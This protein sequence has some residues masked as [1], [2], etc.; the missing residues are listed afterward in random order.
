M[1]MN[2]FKAAFKGTKKRTSQ[3]SSRRRVAKINKLSFQHLEA[4]NL[5]AGIYFSSGEVTIAGDASSN[6]GSFIEVDSETYRARLDGFP[7]QS[8]SKTSVSKVIFIGFEGDDEFTNDTPVESLILGN[9]GNDTLIGGI[10]I[11]VVNGGDGDD[12]IQGFGG[13]DR[14]LGGLG[15]DV[16][17]GG[18]GN[19][20]VFGG[21]GLNRLFGNEDADLI[22]GGSDVDTISGGDG[23]DQIFPLGGDDIVN[24]GDGGLPGATNPADA[25]LVLGGSGNDVLSGGLGLNI[26]Y[27]GDGDDQVTGGDGENRMHGQNGSDSLISGAGNDY[28]AGQ[29]GDDTISGG[30]GND[31]IIPGFGDDVVDAGDGNDFV[32]FSF[33]FNRFNITISGDELVVD[34]TVD[35]EGTDLANNTEN[36]RFSDGDRVA[37][38]DVI[39]RVTINP[40][41]VSN[42]NGSNTAEFLGTAVE[43]AEIKRLIDEIYLQAQVDVE[44][45][46][47]QTYDN[48]FANIGNGGTRPNSD[49][50]TIVNAGDVAGIG[51]SSSLI[52]DM[53]FVEIA[54]GFADTTENTANGLAYVGGNG[55]TMHVGDNLPGFLGGRDV[56]ARVVAHE[57]GHNLGLNH[58]SDSNNL[59]NDGAELNASQIT[60]IVNSSFTQSF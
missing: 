60:T 25:D 55:I 40:I 38:A 22:F 24:L 47:P 8:F 53:Y 58:V 16:I 36:F 14:L 5:L 31:Y 20:R 27:G 30:D 46:A 21:E 28:L 3:A 32:V 2:F 51:D 42:T 23:A 13:D 29:L 4:R 33:A 17:Q 54:A 6:V 35:V 44:W 50:T 52:I 56:V 7:Q 15:A 26:F 37:E 49:L 48:T 19:D 59:M 18:V 10:G 43:E 39:E 57:I 34:D 1:M 11:D 41:I 12:T 45:L 9:G